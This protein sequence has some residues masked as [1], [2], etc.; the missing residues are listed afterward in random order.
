MLVTPERIR[1]LGKIYLNQD[2]VEQLEGYLDNDDIENAKIMLLGTFDRLWKEND[3]NDNEAK[4][5]YSELGIS[6]EKASKLRQA[7][8]KM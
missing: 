3:L 7:S 5:L 2:G 4:Q 8:G 6:P 1:E